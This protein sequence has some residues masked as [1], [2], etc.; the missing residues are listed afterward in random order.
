[1][2]T[3][4]NKDVLNGIIFSRGV[5]Q[6]PIST[7]HHGKGQDHY[8]VNVGEKL[9]IPT[10]VINTNPYPVEINKVTGTLQIVEIQSETK[11]RP[12]NA[13]TY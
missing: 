7:A 10:T 8:N 13:P 3:P 2:F 9:R 4:D 1:M 12:I 5:T 6:V 11:G